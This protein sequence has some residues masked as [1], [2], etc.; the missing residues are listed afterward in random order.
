MPTTPPSL[1]A[2]ALRLLSQREH[3]RAELTAKLA[4]HVQEGEGLSALLDTLEQRGFID[5]ARVAD[6]VQHRRAPLLGTQRVLQEMRRKGLS[7]ELVQKAA[8]EL[9][10]SEIDRAR[11]IWA[12]RFADA[13]AP[14]SAQERARQMRFLA[15]RGFAAEAVRRVVPAMGQGGKLD[16]GE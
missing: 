1:K 15:S 10:G 4:H 14:A 7:D 8:A 9:E 6:S 11:A 2:R 3:S 13:P 5:E 12:R 16:D